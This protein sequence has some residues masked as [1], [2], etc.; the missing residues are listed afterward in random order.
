MGI[1][2]LVWNTVAEFLICFSMNSPAK[3]QANK[4]VHQKIFTRTNLK[5]IFPR[6]IP[7]HIRICQHSTHGGGNLMTYAY[8]STEHSRGQNAE[9]SEGKFFYTYKTAWFYVRSYAP[10]SLNYFLLFPAPWTFCLM[11]PAPWLFWPPFSRIHKKPY[12][13]SKLTH[14]L[15]LSLMSGMWQTPWY[16]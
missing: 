1:S 15:W 4:K 12:R 13:V 16:L 3:K 8:V 10:C 9:R 7:Q 11:P 14:V 2:F 6:V 5:Q